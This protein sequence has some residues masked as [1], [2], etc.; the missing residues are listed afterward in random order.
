MAGLTVHML[1]VVMRQ[2]P[3]NLR[4]GRAMAHATAAADPLMWYLTR[5]LATAAYLTL[6]VAVML[7]MLRSIARQNRERLSWVIDELH[8]VFSTLALVLVLGHLVTLL[9]DPFLPFSL[10][11]LLLPLAEPYKPLPVRLGVLALYGMMLLLLSSWIRRW[12]P[13]RIWR[14]LHYVS[15][16]MFVLVTAHGFFAG[17]DAGEPWAVA[18]YTGTGASVV[19]MSL[20]RIFAGKPAPSQAA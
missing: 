15:F 1:V 11:N 17:S 4:V 7:G 20:M 8:Q 16:L 14:S 5:A 18:L 3:L 10:S 13:Y 9:L 2:A 19:F 6:A 12:I